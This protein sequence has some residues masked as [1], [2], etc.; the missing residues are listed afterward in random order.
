MISP[1]QFIPVTTVYHSGL[2]IRY[3]EYDG[4]GSRL[5][6]PKDKKSPEEK[7][8]YKKRRSKRMIENSMAYMQDHS[9]HKPLL[10]VLTC[11]NG[12]ESSGLVSKFFRNCTTNFDLNYYVWVREYTLK[13][14]PHW[15]VC[16]DMPFRDIQKLSKYWSRL[17]GSNSKVSIRMH[18][19]EKR[20]LAGQLGW[21]YFTKYI[22]KEIDNIGGDIKSAG[23][24]YAISQKLKDASK[25]QTFI[26][27]ETKHLDPYYSLH[28]M[29][30]HAVQFG[31]PVDNDRSA[32]KQILS[33]HNPD[34]PSAAMTWYRMPLTP[35]PTEIV[36]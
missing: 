34:R 24:F 3:L 36:V 33:L 6:N 20:F 12:N 18:S 9:M 23:R 29:D 19:K 5:E 14:L 35:T 15:H 7:L 13:G 30:D 28:T 25:P 11:P 21:L 22:T 17:W 8:L 1:H 16:A 4:P 10:F 32:A 31:T 27:T 26:T 2:I